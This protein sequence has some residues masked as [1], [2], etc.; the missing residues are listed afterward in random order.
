M[1]FCLPE[2]IGLRFQPW[3]VVLLLLLATRLWAAPDPLTYP[4]GANLVPAV[5]G[6]GVVFRVW[7][8]NA[9]TVSAAGQFNG[10]NVTAN[11]MVKDAGSGIWSVWVASATEGQEYKYVLNGT[12]YK[13]DP[14]A[15]DTIN[16]TDN[17]IIRGD[18]STYPW[19][20]TGWQTPDKDKAIVY[21]LHIG[22]FS[23]NGDSAP[24]YPARYRD[25]VDRHLADLLALGVNIVHIMPIHEFPGGVSWGYNP[26]HFFAPESD[27]GTPDDFRYMVD[28]LHQNGIGVILDV[29]YNHVSNSDN[30]LW[31]FD[32]AANIYFFGANCQGSTPW[33]DTRP[34]YT[35]TQVRN[36][37]TDNVRYWMQ[38][39]RLDGLRVDA[40]A[41]M[42]GYCNELGEGWQLMGDITDAARAI[43]P[44]AILIAEE[45]PN[46]DVVTQPRASGG[47]GYDTQWADN[48][49]DVM[50]AQLQQIGA[51][52]SPNVSS[53]SSV[54]TNTGWS[55]ANSEALLYV[56][57]HDEASVLGRATKLADPT[58]P[59]SAKALGV[60]KVVGGLTLLSP[61]MPMLLQGQE[62]GE[63]KNFGDQSADR[64][65]WGFLNTRSGFRQYF[66]TLVSMRK[67]RGGLRSTSGAQVTHTNEGADVLAFQ[68]Y[69]GAG[70]V[71]MVVANLSATAFTS[72][73]LGFPQ[74]GNWHEVVNS[75][76]SSF[77]G[78]G[79]NL[80][81]TRNATLTPR[82]GLPASM[83]VTI[84]PW[85]LLV[86]SQNPLV[87]VE[88]SGFSAE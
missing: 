8:P 47:A 19:Q 59:G 43:N 18:G 40:T 17:G 26:V 4:L 51:N 34:K 69:D 33:G 63:D 88:L 12:S 55:G 11:P 49:G 68:R 41:Y 56:E 77:G 80:N 78:T 76:N 36:F 44:R 5:Q 7:A 2:R 53:I 45:L 85:S 50:R 1:F 16:T 37:F 52:A 46:T 75:N 64:I 72:Y 30:N 20:A 42:R 65:W 82:D 58:T 86:F 24:N 23:G 29:V 79:T 39:F 13:I 15:R 3:A 60:A 83:S 27:Y 35:A 62:F 10:W 22:T 9:T 57:S 87:P 66:S 70:D 61:G 25:V 71:L 54:I 6:G 28:K 38:E 48:F 14:R 74:A 84:P 21:E 81:G 31:N 73:D 32:G 67:A